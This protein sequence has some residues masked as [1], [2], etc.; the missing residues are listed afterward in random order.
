MILGLFLVGIAMYALGSILVFSIGEKPHEEK[1]MG[2][3]WGI[4]GAGI[5]VGGVMLFIA[6]LLFK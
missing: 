3:L 2:N 6:Y 5:A 1:K 4:F